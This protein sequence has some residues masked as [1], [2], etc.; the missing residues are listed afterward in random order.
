MQDEQAV[1]P[2]E[3]ALDEF[4]LA[5]GEIGI[6]EPF[7]DI[8]EKRARFKGAHG[9]RSSGKTWAFAALGVSMAVI[10]R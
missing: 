3:E 6:P 8:F 10:L 7:Q 4:G 1:E 9:G 5:P 2:A